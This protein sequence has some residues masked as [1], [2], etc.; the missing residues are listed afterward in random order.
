MSS[1]SS[2]QMKIFWEQA[3]ENNKQCCRTLF[4]FLRSISY[5]LICLF[6]NL[7]NLFMFFFNC[8]FIAFFVTLVCQRH[9]SCV[10]SL[11]IAF[12][13]YCC[14]CVWVSSISHQPQELIWVFISFF[15]SLFHVY[16]AWE[17]CWRTPNISFWL[18]RISSIANSNGVGIENLSKA[19]CSCLSVERVDDMSKQAYAVQMLITHAQEIFVWYF[20]FPFSFLD[21][22]VFAACSW[23]SVVFIFLSFCAFSLFIQGVDTN[24]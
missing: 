21:R 23:I 10:P 12:F 6:V 5:L 18:L 22:L 11:M 20:S 17:T 1:E 4:S 13:F 24:K 9:D 15:I 7:L 3:P 2:R 8:I 14:N 16:H 19:I